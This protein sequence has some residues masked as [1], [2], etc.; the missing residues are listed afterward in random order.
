[1]INLY[2]KPKKHKHGTKLNLIQKDKLRNGYDNLQ[3]TNKNC[4]SINV[5]KTKI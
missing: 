5:G 1:M 3:T 2:S 4:K